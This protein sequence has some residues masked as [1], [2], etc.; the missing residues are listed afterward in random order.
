MAEIISM[1]ERRGRRPAAAKEHVPREADILFFTGVRYERFDDSSLN[2]P[3]AEKRAPAK[4]G[5][6]RRTAKR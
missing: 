4:K 3:V 2:N 6:A 1:E 5:R